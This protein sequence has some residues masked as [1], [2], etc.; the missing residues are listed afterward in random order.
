MQLC[1]WTMLALCGRVL[2][3]GSHTTCSHRSHSQI[4]H[5]YIAFAVVHLVN[6]VQYYWSWLPYGFR[7]NSVVMIPEYLNMAG[8][9]IYL[10]TATDYYRCVDYTSDVTMRVHHL[11][12]AAASIELVA[13]FGWAVVWWLTF[14]RA[15][16]RGWTLNDP[17]FW[18][19]IFI[20]APSLCY[21]AYN[22]QIL[23]DPTQYGANFLYVTGVRAYTYPH[24]HATCTSIIAGV[25]HCS[26][27]RSTIF[28]VVVAPVCPSAGPII[29]HRGVLLLVCC[30][31]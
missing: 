25:C 28:N 20:V 18:A 8:A 13:A 26:P 11:E 1:C 15:S 21:L 14:P 3:L 19:N 24:S 6:A 7:W 31:A 9:L 22:V 30:P 16:G 12:A 29:R 23:Q 2:R 27:T 5:L 10:V 17:D 4:N